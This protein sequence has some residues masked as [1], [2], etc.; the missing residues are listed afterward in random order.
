MFD[1]MFIGAQVVGLCG[2]CINVFAWQLKNPRHM[3]ITHIPGRSLMAIQYLMLGAPLAAI[4]DTCAVLRDSGISFLKEKYTL[5]MIAFSVCCS[6]GMGLY[7]F[8]H[9]YDVLILICG[10]IVNLSLLLYRNNR[11]AYARA[12]ILSNCFLLAYGVMIYSYMGVIS[13]SLIITSSILGMRRH[14]NWDLKRSP[15]SF[16]KLLFTLP[17]SPSKEVAHV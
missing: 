4:I 14:E 8:Q 13:A 1:N 12:G 7:F 9:W 11:P 3:I 10:T 16:F 6:W 17:S 5:Y 2:L 15:M